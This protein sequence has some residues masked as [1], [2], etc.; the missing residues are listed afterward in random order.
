MD[1]LESRGHDSA[2]LNT[3]GN[4]PKR[5]WRRRLVTV[6]PVVFFYMFATYLYLIIFELYSFNEYGRDELRAHENGS[7]LNV[8]RSK[9]LSTNYLDNHSFSHSESGD[10]AQKNTAFLNLVV[11]GAGQLPSI[12]TCLFL[13]PLSDRLGRKP[14]LVVI[15]VGAC[16]QAAMTSVI[17]HFHLNL[18]YFLVG[19][20]TKAMAGGV[21]GI[22]AGSHSYIADISSRKWLTLRLG[23]VEAATFI[24]GMLSF[25]VGGVWVQVSGCDFR[26]PSY[27]LVA[28]IVV[29][30]PY[31][32]FFLPESLNNREG[33]RQSDRSAKAIVGPKALLRG[34]RIFFSSG[35]SR[36]VLWFALL[37]MIIVISNTS[38][39]YVII[40]LFLLHSP[41]EWSPSLIGSYLAASEL[42]HGL[43]IVFVLPIMV[44]LEMPDS[45]IVLVGIGISCVMDVSLGLVDS[46]WQVF[47]GKPA[48]HAALIHQGMNTGG[49]YGIHCMYCLHYS[50]GKVL[51]D[52]VK[53]LQLSA[54]P[55]KVTMATIQCCGV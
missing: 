8:S 40:T 51:T 28:S 54:R 13:G 34:F 48:S 35:P 43:A 21:A 26:A 11:V 55:I 38:G 4:R 18:Y 42:V 52:I 25:V 5:C 9:C 33:N 14:A 41:L 24:A 36:W 44:A 39:T 45:A 20:V 1:L 29:V 6:E 27:L 15:L 31:V 17:I 16:V 32:I 22:L 19:A 23:I 2:N 46:T 10:N 37:S 47:L 7:S 53:Q 12:L 50:C 3:N 49:V 30:I